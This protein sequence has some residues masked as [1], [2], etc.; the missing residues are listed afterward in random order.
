MMI[1]EAMKATGKL[2]DEARCYTLAQ[3]FIGLA[4]S[5][6]LDP[7][8]VYATVK[9]DMDGKRGEGHSTIAYKATEVMPSAPPTNRKLGE[10]QADFAREGH[11]RL[12]DAEP[13]QGDGKGQNVIADKA[14]LSVPAPS[15]TYRERAGQPGIADK[16]T[17]AVPAAREQSAVD[18]RMAITVNTEAARSV[19]DSYRFGD[20]TA[21]K[22]VRW[23]QLRGFVERGAETLAEGYAKDIRTMRDMLVAAK[24]V[25]LGVPTKASA[26]VGEVVSAQQVEAIVAESQREADRMVREFRKRIKTP[27][28][29]RMIA[30]AME[31]ANAA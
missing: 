21:L 20:G 2:V 24:I 16:A 9:R 1:G 4:R 31:N 17:R 26:T 19:L 27:E 8:S 23:D 14:K 11:R 18:R 12:A 6:G 3:E 7:D 15:P 28:I 25:K 29:K 10:G 30:A 22:L 13:T 5:L